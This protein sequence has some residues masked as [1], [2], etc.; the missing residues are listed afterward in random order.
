MS[1]EIDPRALYTVVVTCPICSCRVR[2]SKLLRAW[3]DRPTPSF[4]DA[5]HMETRGGGRGRIANQRTPLWSLLA[6]IPDAGARYRVGKHIGDF[7]YRL[8][9]RA[10]A[11][12]RA[13]RDAVYWAKYGRQN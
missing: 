8:S 11:V 4:E 7:F 9:A 1:D 5:E 2:A 12:D 6:A 13:A 3:R 10:G